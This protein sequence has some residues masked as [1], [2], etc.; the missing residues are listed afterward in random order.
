MS[1]AIIKNLIFSRRYTKV[2]YD[3]YEPSDKTALWI[4]PGAG[5]SFGFYLF[6]KGRWEP[7]S[8][9]VD[10][11]AL[12]AMLSDVARIEFGTQEQWD[13][14]K[15]LVSEKGKFY[16]Y[17]IAGTDENGNTIYTSRLKL[18]DGNAYLIDIP[19][20]SDFSALE[21]HIN[22]RIIH[23]T[24]EERDRWNNKVSASYI[25]KNENLILSNK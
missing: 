21:E 2:T 22:N 20:L 3:K 14:Q 10:D 7:I 15:D 5:D 1:N 4:K 13:S 11:E 9:S 19:F 17:Q 24:K 16:V 23:I 18:G 8:S 6:N 12:A 25:S